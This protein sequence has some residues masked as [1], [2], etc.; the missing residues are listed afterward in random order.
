M[1]LGR[2]FHR[3][4]NHLDEGGRLVFDV[5]NPQVSLLANDPN[6]RHERARYP[7]PDGRGEVVVEETREYLADRQLVRS[8][9]HYHVGGKREVFV[10]SLD[11]RCFFPCELDLILEHFGFLIEAKYGDVDGGAIVGQSPKQVYVCSRL[12]VIE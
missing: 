6:E 11:L 7:D 2:L 9:R 1:T 12:P 8:T 5:F 3:I 4:I 10:G